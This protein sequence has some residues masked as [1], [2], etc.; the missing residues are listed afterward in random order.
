[1]RNYGWK[2]DVPDQRDYRYYLKS[3]NPQSLPESVDL[4]SKC[5]PV[6]DQGQLGSCT[7]NAL[8]SALEYLELQKKRKFYD[9]SRL[10]VYY[11]ERV[12][13]NSVNS[14]SGAMIRDGI[15]TLA[16]QG[17][18]KENNWKYDIKKFTK[19][20]GKGCYSSA[21]K[22]VINSY[23]RIDSLNEMKQCL[24]SGFPFVFGFS[25]YESFESDLVA[26][27]GEVPMP[28]ENEKLLGG[29]AVMA[30]GYDD[31]TQR[32]IVR[33]SWGENWGNQGYF[34]IPY[35]YLTDRNL[36]D[37]FWTIKQDKAFNN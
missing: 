30:V 22:Y 4:R 18:C 11:N 36:S 17:V 37:D 25:V 27:T 20:P 32:F 31:V 35:I 8:V 33:N 3:T 12:I 16:N 34:T 5:P 21:L 23:Y 2:P 24:V 9:L 26:Q 7:A 15:K 10:F 14:D 13:E 29:H 6:E 19:K 28:A 1:M